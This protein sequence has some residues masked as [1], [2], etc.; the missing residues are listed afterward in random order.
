L[1]KCVVLQHDPGRDRTLVREG[2]EG[3]A[4]GQAAL[5]AK[6]ILLV[7]VHN[8]A[9]RRIYD[10]WVVIETVL[11]LIRHKA[12]PRVRRHDRV[13][14]WNPPLKTALSEQWLSG[15][16]SSCL[17]ETRKLKPPVRPHSLSPSLVNG[18]TWT[19]S[20]LFGLADRMTRSDRLRPHKLVLLFR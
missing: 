5:D 16:P 10:E 15:K 14:R 13:C 18:V 20:S 7:R 6:P 12:N 17:A 4:F 8:Q 9:G 2:P 3:W 19:A 1:L 11:K